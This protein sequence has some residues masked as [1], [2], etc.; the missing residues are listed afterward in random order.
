MQANLEDL[1]KQATALAKTFP[2]A[3]V[4]VSRI[5]TDLTGQ[6]ILLRKFREGALAATAKL[7]YLLGLDP[8]SDLVIVD[9]NLIAFTLVNAEQS[10]DALVAEAQ[11]H[12]PGVR[13]LEGLLVTIQEAS[14]KDTC[15][16]QL[17][18]VVDV[19]MA[20]GFFGTGPGQSLDTDNRW[21]FGVQVRWNLT[22][23]V[24]R[25]DKLRHS[26]QD[27]PGPCHLPGFARQADDGR[28]AIARIDPELPRSV[29]HR[30]A[31][32]EACDGCLRAQQ[33]SPR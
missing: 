23:W 7:I 27:R 33:E 10:A 20:E 21:D 4:E 13:E 29:D 9:R 8:A 6:E 5:Q 30:R 11:V 25:R 24:T 2:A 18:P 17:L 15:L 28:A 14:A 16:S 3:E 32:A 26:G 31:A 19:R 1:L 12:G 22:E